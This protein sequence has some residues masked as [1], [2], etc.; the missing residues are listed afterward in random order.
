M[1][2]NEGML[3]FYIPQH[4]LDML[5]FLVINTRIWLQM[6]IVFGLIKVILLTKLKLKQYAL[7][8]F[9]FMK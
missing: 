3:L 2:E 6:F 9:I 1:V 7:Y 8:F 4:M 5:F